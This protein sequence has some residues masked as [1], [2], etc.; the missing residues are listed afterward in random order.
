MARLIDILRSTPLY[1]EMLEKIPEDQRE[2]AVAALEKQLMPYELLL[3]SLPGAAV[4][5]LM[6]SL[7]NKGSA[8][9]IDPQSTRR[10]PR[11]F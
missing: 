5:N 6:S 1:S 7:S 11:R 8:A 9:P 4:E 3:S 10:P 2:A